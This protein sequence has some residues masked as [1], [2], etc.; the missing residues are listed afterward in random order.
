MP[1]PSDA[2]CQPRLGPLGWLRA[3]PG[4]LCALPGRLRALPCRLRQLRRPT[5]ADGLL[6]LFARTLVRLLHGGGSIDDPAIRAA[7]ETPGPVIIVGNHTAGID[8][9]LVQLTTRRPIRW[10]MA[11][12]MMSPW[13]NWFWRYERIIPVHY[14]ARDARGAVEAI[15]H[16]RDGHALGLFP[17]GGI[18]RPPGAIRPFLG[19]FGSMAVKTGA[20]VVLVAIEGTPR[21][22]TAFGSLF[23]PS[24]S[25]VRLV[26]VFEPGVGGGSAAAEAL[27]KEVREALAEAL[28]WPLDDT[29]LEHL[30]G[31]G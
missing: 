29:P 18:E 5:V 17:E 12:D 22:K 24:I 31:R 21:C 25:R 30:A 14:D 16:L 13:A 8:P 19:G 26:K 11:A 28:G 15:R 2:S 10:F 9:I 20:R 23:Q 6:I 27:V 3:L 4:R 7:M 1:S